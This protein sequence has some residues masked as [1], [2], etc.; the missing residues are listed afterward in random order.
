MDSLHEVARTRSMPRSQPDGYSDDVCH[1]PV[2]VA[3]GTIPADPYQQAI[4][5]VA[6]ALIVATAIRLHVEPPEPS[7]MLA[8][9]Y[10]AFRF[11]AASAIARCHHGTVAEA[12]HE[13]LG[14]IA[15]EYDGDVLGPY[16]TVAREA[17]DQFEAELEMRGRQAAKR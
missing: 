3:S 5:T 11:Q 10:A 14:T 17:I 7:Q 2:L 4:D 6:R 1:G 16:A 13:V 8:T 9:S 15:G 12:K